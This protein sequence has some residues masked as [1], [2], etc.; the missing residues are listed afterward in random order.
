MGVSAFRGVW[1]AASALFAVQ[2]FGQNLEEMEFSQQ[3]VAP[4]LY[5]LQHMAGGNIGLLVGE[6]GVLMIDDHISQVSE[7]LKAAVAEVTDQPIKFLVNTH[8]H[9]DHTGNNAVY[10]VEGS[11]IVAH[12]NVRYRLKN[13]QQ[14]SAFGRPVPPAPQEALPVI[15]FDEG[16]SFHLNDET[17]EVL[18]PPPAHTDGDAVVYFKNANVAHLGD[19]YWN[20]FYPLVDGTSGGSLPGMIAGIEAALKRVNADTKIIPGHGMLSNR[21]QLENFLQMLKTSKVRVGKLKDAGNTLEE[22]VAAAPL[23]DLDATWGQ[24]FIKP[25]LWLTIVYNTL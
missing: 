4:G 17:V 18:H 7:K 13:G 11:I 5:M 8:W 9:F 20:G 25:E 22:V 15:T 16:L 10:G 24:G 1:L 2:A 21:A 3:E 19:M 14:S 12:D 6:D 23:K